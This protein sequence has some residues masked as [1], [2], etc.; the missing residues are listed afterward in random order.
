[1]EGG[2]TGNEEHTSDRVHAYALA[3][4]LRIG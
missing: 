1:V 3:V 2:A 4:G